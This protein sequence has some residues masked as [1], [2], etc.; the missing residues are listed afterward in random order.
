MQVRS[1]ERAGRRPA[2]ILLDTPL[3]ADALEW[4]ISA[5]A[6]IA[7]SVLGSGHPVRLLGGTL[8]NER[9]RHLGKQHPEE[10][11]VELLNQTIDLAAPPSGFTANANLLRAINYAGDDLAQGEVV[12]GVFEPLNSACL[13]ALAPL[14]E[15]GHAWAIVRA[16]SDGDDNAAHC[17]TALRRSGWRAT[18]ATSRDDLSE[19]WTILLTAGDIE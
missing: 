13:E 14:G 9:K 11:R 19:I 17:A 3:A 10:A 16:S 15:T 7:V 4:S 6:S 1:D 18:T 5:A 12:V 2:T 8:I